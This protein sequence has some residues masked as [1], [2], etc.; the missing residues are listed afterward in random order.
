M[1]IKE[2]ID[3]LVKKLSCKYLE[4]IAVSTKLIIYKEKTL[5]EK[6]SKTKPNKTAK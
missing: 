5:K 1:R 2:Y 6:T 4:K 3:L